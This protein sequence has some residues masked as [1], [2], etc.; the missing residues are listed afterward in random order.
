MNSRKSKAFEIPPNRHVMVAGATR[1]GKSF[2][3]EQY[4]KM[5]YY[6]IKLDTKREAFERK[7]HGKSAWEGLV[8]GQDFTVIEKLEDIVNVE[9]PKIIYAPLPEEQK[10]E[11]YE[12]FFRFIYE[13]EDTV[14]W[15]DETMSFTTAT[16]YPQWFKNL[17]IMGASKNIGVWCCTQ[18]PLGIPSI[19][20][21][22]VSYLV[23]FNLNQLQDRKRLV[24]ISGCNDFLESPS[25]EYEDYKFFFYRIGDEKPTVMKVVT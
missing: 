21:A 8:E 20:G 9:T 22:N 10:M 5:Y 16:R 4:L 7:R 3:T 25:T 2:F 24:E 14:V 1:S 6:V 18:R 12:E 17:L 19:I 13:R 23:I 11:Y 15:C